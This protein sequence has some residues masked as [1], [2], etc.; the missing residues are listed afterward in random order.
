M[1]IIDTGIWNKV[2]NEGELPRMDVETYVSKETMVTFALIVFALV[3][4]S[5]LVIRLTAPQK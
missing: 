4:A 2:I 3:V 5:V 1:S